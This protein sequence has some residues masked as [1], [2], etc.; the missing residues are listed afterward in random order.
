[1]ESELSVEAKQVDPCSG[2]ACDASG[3]FWFIDGDKLYVVHPST[4][5]RATYCG[6]LP[7][8]LFEPLYPRGK[9]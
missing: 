9:R 8:I 3:R 7:Q 1:M 5:G 6:P 2:F 4:P